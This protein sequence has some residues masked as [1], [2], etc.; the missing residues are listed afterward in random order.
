MVPARVARLTPDV[1]EAVL[2][3]PPPAELGPA[4]RPVARED[5]PEQVR[6]EQHAAAL[7]VAPQIIKGHLPELERA[8]VGRLERGLAFR[9]RLLLVLVEH[10]LV[11]PRELLF[12]FEAI[13][14]REASLVLRTE[15]QQAVSG[16]NAETDKEKI[17][18]NYVLAAFGLSTDDD[19]ATPFR[20]QRRRLLAPIITDSPPRLDLDW[21]RL[22]FDIRHR[23]RR[24]SLDALEWLE[25]LAD[26]ERDKEIDE[27]FEFKDKE[28]EDTRRGHEL[29]CTYGLAAVAAE[30]KRLK[31]RRRRNFQRH[32]IPMPLH[33]LELMMEVTGLGP[34]F[35][36][37]LED[38]NPWDL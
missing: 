23:K 22:Y 28:P 4:P 10:V 36:P 7:D 33:D 24:V 13:A 30:Q 27:M 38:E 9:G 16:L 3:H 15:F 18:K 1:L 25:G 20:E 11:A 21:R 6:D 2:H 32:P 17:F 37:D 35:F 5:V 19:D 8:R 12:Q 29:R 14:D 34:E 31:E 26:P